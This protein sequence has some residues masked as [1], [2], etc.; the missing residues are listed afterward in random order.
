MEQTSLLSDTI[1]EKKMNTIYKTNNTMN[2]LKNL[3]S[4]FKSQKK[5]Q[6]FVAAGIVFT[7]GKLILAGYQPKK[8]YPYISGIGGLKK[9]NETPQE[10]AIRETLEEIFHIE[11]V[12]E[13]ILDLIKSIISSKTI[14]NGTYVFFVY[15]F[16]DLEKLLNIVNN[17][18]IK[19]PLY[20]QI[21][22]TLSELM[23]NRDTAI[24]SE[25]S[26][27]CLLPL[28]KHDNKLPLVDKNL[29]KDMKQILE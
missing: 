27:L 22:T 18:G 13:H 21:P 2:Y 6:D 4:C 29:I 14:T 12:E 11:N 5:N 28:V 9:N 15:S 24:E 19:S 1:F 26:H 10:T 3:F 23:L 7:D 25:I 8:T 17:F 20:K 16:N